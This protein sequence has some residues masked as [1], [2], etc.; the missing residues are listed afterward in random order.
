MTAILL[1]RVDRISGLEWRII[2]HEDGKMS[3]NNCEFCGLPTNPGEFF[4]LPS[5]RVWAHPECMIKRG[6]EVVKSG[7]VDDLTV[8]LDWPDGPAEITTGRRI[9][10]SI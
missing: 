9:R 10:E 8:A 7:A 6:L 1:H 3:E 5:G 4:T 2:P